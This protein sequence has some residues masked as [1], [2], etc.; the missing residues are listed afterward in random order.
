MN[1]RYSAWKDMEPNTRVTVGLGLSVSAVE[2][3]ACDKL[4][5]WAFSY[6][7]SMFAEHGLTAI[8]SPTVPISAPRIPDGGIDA[9]ESNTE[10]VVEMMK[11]IFLS[12]FLGMPSVSVRAAA[13]HAAA[14]CV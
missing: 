8:V 7:N 13:Y 3:L 6:V 11:Y 9:G 14:L 5:A 1:N 2:A 4:R 10:L 12:N